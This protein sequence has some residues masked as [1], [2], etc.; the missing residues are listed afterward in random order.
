M[1]DATGLRQLADALE[2]HAR[3]S[4]EPIDLAAREAAAADV[5]RLIGS[6]PELSAE[7][8]AV[9]TRAALDLRG[10]GWTATRI[11]DVAGVTRSAISQLL[12]AAQ[13]AGEP[14]RL[15]AEPGGLPRPRRPTTMHLTATT[16]ATVYAIAPPNLRTLLLVGAIGAGYVALVLGICQLLKASAA[17]PTPTPPGRARARLHL[18][19]YSPER[20]T[21]PT[22]TDLELEPAGAAVDR[23]RSTIKARKLRKARLIEELARAT[24]LLEVRT[25]GMARLVDHNAELEERLRTATAV[26]G[27]TVALEDL[28]PALVDDLRQLGDEY[29]PRG[30]IRAASTVLGGRR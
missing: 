23:L 14:P 15:L 26:D 28:S 11:A 18:V 4:A 9:R 29:G 16:A 24:W 10:T 17:T 8:T 21:M 13:P 7:L 3:A 27:T 12:G 30:V 1:T 19:T 20:T 5:L 22:P 6:V 25:A 2:A